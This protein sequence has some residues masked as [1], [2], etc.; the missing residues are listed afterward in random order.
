LDAL[1]SLAWFLSGF[2]E[3]RFISS[4]CPPTALWFSDRS[5]QRYAPCSLCSSFFAVVDAL[6]VH[7]GVNIKL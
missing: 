3:F 6:P 2:I 1:L 7:A 4:L 5:L